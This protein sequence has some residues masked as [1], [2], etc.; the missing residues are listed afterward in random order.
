MLKGS[1][2][3][4]DNRPFFINVDLARK[5]KNWQSMGHHI[6]KEIREA[7]SESSFDTLN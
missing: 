2:S 5:G 1:Y 4:I 6:A 7:G 3:F